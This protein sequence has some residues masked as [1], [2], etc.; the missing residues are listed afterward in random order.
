MEKCTYC[1][2]R[3]SDARI[4]AKKANL[5]IPDGGV[6][7]ACQQACPSQ[8]IIFGNKADQKSGVAKSLKDPRAYMLL[9][10]LNTC[11]RTRHCASA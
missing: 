5:P 11:P 9:E 2:Q 1:V 10:D 3:I 7:S 6:V 4:E 8:A